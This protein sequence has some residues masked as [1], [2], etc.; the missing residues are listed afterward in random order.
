[1][2][3]WAKAREVSEFTRACQQMAL[4]GIRRRHPGADDRELQL[5]LA[6]LWLDRGTMVRC[7]GWDPEVEG[8][9]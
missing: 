5:R 6:A 1:M 8:Y 2:P 3:S 7:F 4:A 9:G